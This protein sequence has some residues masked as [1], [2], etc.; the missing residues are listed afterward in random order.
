MDNSN[1]YPQ[2]RTMAV[3]SSSNIAAIEYTPGGSTTD[4][5]GTLK[6][7]FH[8]GGAYEYSNFSD[9]LAEEFFA[10]ESKGRFFHSK[11]KNSF[12][13]VKVEEVP[14][15]P[16]ETRFSRQREL[17][18]EATGKLESEDVKEVPLASQADEA[19]LVKA[20]LNQDLP[21]RYVQSVEDKL[22]PHHS[23]PNG[24]GQEF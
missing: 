1:N 12:I 24:N 5:F 21:E 6:I 7:R 18:T 9:E 10:A 17:E 11:I 19:A 16:T 23:L 13:G 3:E 2:T 15:E 4:F 14:E 22:D 20:G 8:N